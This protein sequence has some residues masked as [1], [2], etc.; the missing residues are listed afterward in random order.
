MIE[1]DTLLAPLAN[2]AA[3][4]GLSDPVDMTLAGLLVAAMGTSGVFLLRAGAGQDRVAE[5]L[6][7]LTRQ[8]ERGGQDA[9]FDTTTDDKADEPARDTLADLLVRLIRPLPLIGAQEQDRVERQLSR[10]GIRSPRGVPLF[11]A[12]KLGAAAALGAGAALFAWLTPL[13]PASPVAQAVTALVGALV[14]G[15][16]PEIILRGRAAERQK[17][18]ASSLPDALD[19]LVICAEAGLSLDVAVTRV[20]GEIDD[21]AP[22]LGQE[23]DTLAA[24]LRLLPDRATPLERLA[25]RVPLPAVTSLV[26][27]LTQSQKYGTSLAQS[28]RVISLE[29]RNARMLSVEEKAA[30]IPALISVPLILFVLPAIFLI[31]AGPAALEIAGMQMN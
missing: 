16:V 13:I 4:V 25:D 11:I 9:A 15:M 8:V 18:I 22:E 14:G 10:A 12:A 7:A 29:I 26:A 17:R 31:V 19:L 28:M 2:L 20:S 3:Q 1:L 21:G 5:R 6:D 23:L 27:T 24:E 30:K